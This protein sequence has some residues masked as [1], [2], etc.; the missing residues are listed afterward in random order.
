MTPILTFW[1]IEIVLVLL[2]AV[3]F[4]YA[5]EYSPETIG[6]ILF[7]FAC[8]IAAIAVGVFPFVFNLI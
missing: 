6:K 4:W 3:T 8:L 7:V 1:L 2:F 5:A